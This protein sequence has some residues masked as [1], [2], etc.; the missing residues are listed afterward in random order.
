[1]NSNSLIKNIY[2]ATLGTFLLSISINFILSVNWGM[3]T[4]D[5]TCLTVQHLFSF[6]K[7]G[8]AVFFTHM[9]FLLLLIFFK[10]KMQTTW[11]QIILAVISIY[12]VSRVIN[13]FTFISYIQYSNSIVM[14]LIFM[15]S[16]FIVNL[17]ILLMAN[18]GLIA[19][20]YDRFV[21][22]YSEITYRTLGSA[23][24]IV[25]LFTFGITLIIIITTNLNIPI[26]IAT[27]FIVFASGPIIS[28]WGRVL[29]I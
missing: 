16:V 5:T 22:Q 15:A 20:P 23:R 8:D 12:I 9:V 4:F 27:F 14:F 28:F 7:Y 29:K 21:I 10:T 1:M 25:D 18:S 26:S 3:S 17:G 11:K 13:I 19:T 2:L 24:L 6:I